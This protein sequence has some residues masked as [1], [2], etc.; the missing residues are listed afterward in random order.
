MN[1]GRPGQ[2]GMIVVVEEFG[3]SVERFESEPGLKRR[4]ERN[5]TWCQRSTLY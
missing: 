1:L 2:R 5:R 3:G 4:G